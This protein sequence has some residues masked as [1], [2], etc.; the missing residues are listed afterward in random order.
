M[1]LKSSAR[2]D[3]ILEARIKELEQGTQRYFTYYLDNF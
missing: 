1:S 3:V 2:Y